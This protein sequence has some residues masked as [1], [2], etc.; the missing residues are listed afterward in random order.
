MTEAK[1]AV[2]LTDRASRARISD[3]LDTTFLVEAG[4]GSGKTKSLVDRM[5]ALIATGRATIQT[6]AAVTFT[7]KAAAQLRGRFQVALERSLAD[8]TGPG[9]RAW[10]PGEKDRLRAALRDLEQGFVG[11]IH[12]CC[13]RLIRERPVECGVDPE[14]VEM[15]EIDDAVFREACWHDFLHEARLR[16]DDLLG[17]LDDVGL[18]P[19][20]LRD[21]F[22]DLAMYPEVE[23]APGRAEAPDYETARAGL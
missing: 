9:D 16:P 17:D 10:G 3:D 11:T 21:A 1:K 20:D 13:A 4:A 18:S 6:M 2:P 8:K 7:R 14:F 19:E 22:D 5:I 23:P 12:S 15:E